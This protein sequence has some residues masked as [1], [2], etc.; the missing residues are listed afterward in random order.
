MYYT[1]TTDKQEYEM[2]VER[3]SFKFNYNQIRSKYELF[4]HTMIFVFW[5]YNANQYF[6]QENEVIST[7]Q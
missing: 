2:S 4:A 7:I 3:F 6:V 1:T 5:L